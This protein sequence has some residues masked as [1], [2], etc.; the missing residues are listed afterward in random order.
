MPN[1]AARADGE[2]ARVNAHPVHDGATRQLQHRLFT[3]GVAEDRVRAIYED[4]LPF[5]AGEVALMLLARVRF[6]FCADA[7]G[8]ARGN[9]HVAIVFDCSFQTT[10]FPRKCSEAAF[11]GC[12]KAEEFRVK[13]DRRRG[14]RRPDRDSHAFIRGRIFDLIASGEKRPEVHVVPFHL[15]FFRRVDG[16]DLGKGWSGE[17]RSYGKD[18]ADVH[19]RSVK[20]ASRGF[21]SD[22]AA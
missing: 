15:S 18:D 4:A 8:P 7:R 3:H 11:P 10:T 17:D 9:V 22:C 19:K 13:K 2:S 16:C 6:D 12:V 21:L 20:C 14:F 5:H 1:V